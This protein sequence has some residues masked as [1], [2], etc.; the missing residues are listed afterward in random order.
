M[1]KF[2]MLMLVLGMASLATAGL[3]IS[4]NGSTDPVDSEISIA[5]SDMLVLDV[6]GT[7]TTGEFWFMTVDSAIGSVSGGVVVAGD[8]SRIVPQYYLDYW[9]YYAGLTA[10]PLVN[11]PSN[12]TVGGFVGNWDMSPIAGPAI[13]LIDFHCESQPNDAV[14]DLWSSPGGAVWTLV[15]TATIHQIPE[16]MTMVLLGLGGLLLRRRK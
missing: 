14:I 8:A 5:P 4:V 6:H 9:L 15:D 10:S 13:D 16:P 7:P 2:V 12:S 1:K 3:Q 11:D